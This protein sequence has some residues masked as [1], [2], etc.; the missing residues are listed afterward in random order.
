LQKEDLMLRVRKTGFTLIELLVVIAIIAILIALLLPAV[1]QAREA[2]R[3]TQCRN[4]LKQFGLAFH[5]YHD[6]HKR[7]PPPSVAG[8]AGA[9]Q[10]VAGGWPWSM[11]LLP[12]LDQAPLYNQIGVG[13]TL[14][15]P[16][17]AANMTNVDDFTTAAAGSIERLLTTKIPMFLCPSSSGG[18]L[19]KFEKNLGTLMYAAN[20]QIMTV[21][22]PVRAFPISDIVD[23][24]S[25]T[26]LMGEKSLMDAPFTAVGCVWATSRFC[27]ARLHIVAAQNNMNTPFDGTLN[28]T[29]NCY[30]ENG[31]PVNLV[32]RA[33]AASSH[34]GGCHFLMCD[35]AVRF[36]SENIA[37][38]PVRPSNGN[39]N[40]LYQN[41]YRINDKQT[42]GEF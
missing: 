15:V 7:F 4:N 30:Q 42:L 36:I 37:A 35:G 33:V 34:T 27:G 32:T 23:G 21:P 10:D 31:T 26:I 16:R 13:Q 5:N 14:R 38:D 12:Y 20:N 29:T 1:Q 41:L 19:N 2:A 18:A 9:N 28:T 3:R 17:N 39:G 24:T 25:N 22:N 11:M 6:A 40:Y 8:G